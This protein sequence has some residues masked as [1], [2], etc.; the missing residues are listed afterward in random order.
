LDVASLEDT[1]RGRQTERQ[2]DRQTVCSHYFNDIQ[3]HLQV[4]DYLL[5]CRARTHISLSKT[6][7]SY[8]I[9]VK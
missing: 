5:L 8:D 7:I 1:H 3:T 2:T 4:V 6:M 9:L